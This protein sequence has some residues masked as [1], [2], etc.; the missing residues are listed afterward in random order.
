MHV[1][2]TRPHALYLLALLPLWALLVWPWAGRGVPYTRGAGAV[3]RARGA[4]AA[5]ALVL[6]G[7]RILTGLALASLVVA[8]SAPVRVGVEQDTELL[9]HGISLVVDLS[10]S[11]L[12]QD[13]GNQESRIAL[14]REAA[15]AFARRRAHDELSLVGFGGEAL[16]RVPPTTDRNLVVDGVESL[17]VQLVRDGTDISGAVLTAVSRLLQSPREPRVLVLLTDGSHNGPNVPPLVA[18]RAA[19]AL[20]VRIHAISILSPDEAS[21]LAGSIVRS[22]Y[23]EER[24]TVLQ[25]LASLTGGQYF[26]ATNAAALD[27]IYA[28]IDRVEAPTPHVVTHETREPLARWF[29]LLALGLLSAEALV[30]GSRWGIVH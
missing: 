10:S 19:A 9:G 13:M 28:Q 14:A 3:R 18:A 7:P 21:D 16:T 20:G 22:S 8:L 24:E 17:Q 23:G 29:F 15:V 12:A 4:G 25:R 2:L 26:R 5:R 11:M 30:R 27:S 1:E 6:V